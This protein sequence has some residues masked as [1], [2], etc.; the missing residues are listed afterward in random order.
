MI[1]DQEW[2]RFFGKLAERGNVS[3]ACLAS[4][5]SRTQLYAWKRGEVPEGTD[6]AA[7]KARY[8]EALEVS[9]DRLESEAFR[10]A[11]DGVDEPIIGRVGKDQD[12]I[13]TTVKK[14][15]DGLLTL[16]LK[17]H[18]PEKFKDRV[19]SELTGKDGGPIKTENR[20][21]CLPA[22]DETQPE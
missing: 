21:I 18:R 4:G 5:V 3:E 17:A 16:L 1:T 10:R 14:Y 2:D 15:S 19:A 12:G 20:V 22:I 7:W 11:H 8:D 9:M 6:H 13:I